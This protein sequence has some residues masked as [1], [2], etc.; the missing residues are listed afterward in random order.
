VPYP[1]GA[2]TPSALVNAA[3]EHCFHQILSGRLR[4]EVD[5][6]VLTCDTIGAAA[7]AALPHLSAAIELSREAT[8]ETPP[9]LMKP[10]SPVVKGALK[11][12]HFGEAD[13]EAIRKRWTENEIVAVEL[14]VPVRPKD[15]ADQIGRVKLYM[16]RAANADVARETYVRGR[17]S[18]P[19]SAKI[20]GKTAVCLLVA[21]EGAASRILGDSEGPAHSR[22]IADRVKGSYKGAGDTLRTIRMALRDLHA[23]AAQVQSQAAIKDALKDFFWMKKPPEKKKVEITGG[24]IK[25]IIE[26]PQ[27]ELFEL[28]RV[29]GGFT[30][31]C[32][33]EGA[34]P[35]DARVFVAYD[36]RRGRPRWNEADF[37]L[38][39][40]HIT[41]EADGDGEC[42][43]LPD[44]L[45]I[46]AAKPGFNLKVTGF[47]PTRDLFV[48]LAVLE[49]E[50][51][52]GA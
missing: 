38:T 16:R 39:N 22:W 47:L 36:R 44:G 2:L 10:I 41:I 9:V 33:K 42:E 6:I 26:K 43:P 13:L 15:G 18:V 21:D 45:V 52:H 46:R 25:P 30:V 51:A 3:I 49:E 7:Q 23:I 32:S 8:S 11:P 4:V 28:D 40:G 17:V 1:V 19:E 34:A 35:P 50:A 5:D 29:A 24:P 31:R 14:P 20:I 48:R 12:E 37:D 27:Q